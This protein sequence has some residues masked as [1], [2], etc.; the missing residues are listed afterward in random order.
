MKSNIIKYKDFRFIN[1]FNTLIPYEIPSKPLNISKK[2]AKTLLKQTGA[3]LIR[4]Y[5]NWDKGNETD[6]WFIIK[7]TEEVLENYKSKYRYQINKGLEN[8][9]VKKVTFEFILENAYT[10]YKSAFNSYNTNNSLISEEK[11]KQEITETNNQ[12]DEYWA[13]FKKG[14]DVFIAYAKSII[15]DNSVNYTLMKYNPE[16][17]TKL[18]SGYALVYIMNKYYLNDKKFLFVNDGARSML[19][20]TNIQGFLES[21]FNFRKAYCDLNVVFSPKINFVLS[22]IYPFRK[23]I[24]KQNN[25]ILKK[26]SVL[27]KHKEYSVND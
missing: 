6:F 21:K 23:F 2:E 8:C 22:F 15:Q 13:V 25:S 19:H 10:V 3:Y 12:T 20:D 24:Y 14:S 5:S 16:Y 17:K 26:I 18:Y 9:D 11:F 7:D 4:W 1:Y 27:L